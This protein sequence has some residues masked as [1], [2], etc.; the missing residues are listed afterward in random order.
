MKEIGEILRQARVARGLSLHDVQS[1]LKIRERYLVALEEGDPS[2]FPALVY[3]RGFLRSYATYLGLDAGE[4]LSRLPSEPELPGGATPPSP[5]PVAF[6]KPQP[7]T[8]P[9]RQ[10]KRV[11]RPGRLAVPLG[12]AVALVVA[13]G[14]F[15]HRLHRPSAVP[16][17]KVSAL[18]PPRVRRPETSR[19]LSRTQPPPVR[20]QL[21]SQ[22]GN[23]PVVVA[24]T[25]GPIR[26]AVTFHRRCWVG[27]TAD[28]VQ[29]QGEWTSGTHVFTAKHRL[30]L[31]FGA[32]AYADVQVN[33]HGFGPAGNGP[34]RTWVFEA[35]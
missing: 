25:P 28:G 16:Q 22:T 32:P 1:D 20:V 29:S 17:K 18:R 12:V 15:G 10:G 2:P 26:V 11:F 31:L 24:V 4:L 8:P 34:P 9:R 23:G 30:S 3:L 13:A 5:P 35:R 6:T 19:H 14:I 7:M 21:V 27:I 33:G